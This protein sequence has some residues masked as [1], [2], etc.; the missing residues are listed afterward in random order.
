MF[1]WVDQV[2]VAGSHDEPPSRTSNS[3]GVQ[4]PACSWYTR[5]SPSRMCLPVKLGGTPNRSNARCVVDPSGLPA[6]NHCDPVKFVP[7]APFHTNVSANNENPYNGST[8]TGYTVAGS[9]RNPQSGLNVTVVP[10]ASVDSFCA[11][12]R[13]PPANPATGSASAAHIDGGG[14]PTTTAPL[15]S[16]A[17]NPPDASSPAVSPV[18]VIPRLSDT[19][20]AGCA[21][22]TN[23]TSTPLGDTD[24][25]RSVPG[26]TSGQVAV[27]PF[28]TGAPSDAGQVRPR[29]FPP[30]DSD[31]TGPVPP[32]DRDSPNGTA[33]ATS[34]P[35]ETRS[36]VSTGT[37]ESPCR[38]RT[39]PAAT[40]AVNVP[41]GLA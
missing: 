7:D 31:A 30:R 2:T 41:S 20:P 34:R 15:P 23:D 21:R 29:D 25:A 28:T 38:T 6:R 3:D 19:G 9:D 13:T 11:T 14:P 1:G 24:T 26:A 36:A 17:V 39:G 12:G 33:P 10:E 5:R 37:Q 40:S 22:S 18:D 16:R 32:A 8:V 27:F 35:P 4:L